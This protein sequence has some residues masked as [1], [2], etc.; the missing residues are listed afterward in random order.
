MR[1]AAIDTWNKKISLAAIVAFVI[2]LAHGA[3]FAL[4]H[5]WLKS[6]T[7]SRGFSVLGHSATIW[8]LFSALFLLTA[9]IAAFLNSFLVL[10]F[11]E[12]IA[13]KKDPEEEKAVLGR[14]ITSPANQLYKG[15]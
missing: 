13:R 3:S 11:L 6:F 12:I 15:G 7:N 8:I 1:T 9:L 14:L 10:L 4:V 5:G 2:I